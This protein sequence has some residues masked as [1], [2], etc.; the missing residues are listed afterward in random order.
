MARAGEIGY[1]E[2]FAL[3][4]DREEVLKTL[5]PGSE[6]YYYYYSLHYQQT[7]QFEKVDELLKLWVGRYQDSPRLREIQNRQ[8]LLTYDT[9]PQ[10]SLDF[11]RQRLDLRF[12]HQREALGTRPDLPTQLDAAL[13]QSRATG[14]AGI[15]A[16]P[17]PG[18]FRGRRLCLAARPSTQCRTAAAPA[19]T[20][21]PSR[22]ARAA[23]VDRRRTRATRRAS[24]SA[25]CPS[26]SNFCGSN[27]TNY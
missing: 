14:G 10:Q 24:L 13:H 8:A 23:A 7:R 6:D 18:R 20:L 2:D 15:P 1:P 19:G 3:A 21:D 22:L 5:I 17:E 27:W 9:R 11:L 12:D 26:I 25:A 4:R 16:A